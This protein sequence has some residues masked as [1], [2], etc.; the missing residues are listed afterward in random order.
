[1]SIGIVI[2]TYKLCK[3]RLENLAFNLRHMVASGIPN[4]YVVEQLSEDE[5]V[6]RVLES[7]PSVRYITKSIE[8]DVF[9]KSKLINYS[10]NE[11]QFEYIWIYDVDV[12][13][14]TKFVIRSIPDSVDVVRPF[15][16]IIMLNE[17]ESEKL[18]R[19]DLIYLDKRSYDGY[20]SFGKFSLILK[21][22]IF[23]KVGGYDETFQGWGFQDLDLTQRIPGGCYEGYMTNTGF[24]MWHPR[25]STEFD[26][27]NKAS[28]TKR[29]FGV[30][31]PPRKKKK[32]NLLD[33]F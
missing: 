25:P 30:T 6:R 1:M 15:E 20:N 17:T 24:H 10:V 19:T 12:F 26:Q 22:D 2:P 11:L 18:K 27:T 23:E 4:I 8:G 21:R 32:K 7:F 5:S 13:M 33:S 9:N 14:D 31:K 3:Y 29:H 28:F 16:K